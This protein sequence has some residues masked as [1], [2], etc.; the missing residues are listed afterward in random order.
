MT[1]GELKTSTEN[2]MKESVDD[3]LLSDACNDASESLALSIIQFRLGLFMGGMNNQSNPVTLSIAAGVERLQLTSLADP[4]LPPAPGQNA[5]GTLPG[6]GPITFAYTWVTESGSETKLSPTGQVTRLA[7]HQI[8]VPILTGNSPAGTYG[9][10]IYAAANNAAWVKQNTEPLDLNVLNWLEPADTGVNLD[11]T[12]GSGSA[13]TQNT[14]GD[15]IMMIDHLET[16]MPDGTWKAYNAADLDSEMMRRAARTISSTSP[17]QNYYWDL[18]GNQLEIRPLTGTALS[19]RYF[20]VAKPRRMKYDN[21]VLPF[22]SVSGAALQLRCFAISLLKLASEEY[23][24][25]NLWAQK[26]SGE[27]MKILK[28]LNVANRNRNDR[29]TPYIYG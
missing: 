11:A 24:A 10:N 25:S 1:F 12:N 29:I 16:Q 3:A 14:T 19:S 9:Y 26:A 7:N 27:E 5:G 8:S 20:F 17:Y 22:E 2:W 21:A 6:F 4:T 28:S 15:N 23:Q 13:P 18:L